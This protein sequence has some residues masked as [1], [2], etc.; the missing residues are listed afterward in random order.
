[1]TAVCRFAMQLDPLGLLLMALGVYGWWL[2]GD[3]KRRAGGS[4]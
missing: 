1:M 4:R 3:M 2:G